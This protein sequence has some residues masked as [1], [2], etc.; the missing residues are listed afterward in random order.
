MSV[1][2]DF[3]GSSGS[4][5]V[6]NPEKR[7]ADLLRVEQAKLNRLVISGASDTQID[8]L[9]SE[10]DALRMSHKQAMTKAQ[11][12]YERVL[13]AREQGW[14]KE[15]T[16][17]KA[18][19]SQIQTEL[20]HLKGEKD[21]KERK[22]SEEQ[23]RLQQE[24][25]AMKK[26]SKLRAEEQH[27]L[28]EYLKNQKHNSDVVAMIRLQEMKN[29]L[30]M[31]RKL[32]ES[33]IALQETTKNLQ[34][35]LYQLE[36]S[37]P[38]QALLKQ[39]RERN[40]PREKEIIKS[41]IDIIRSNIKAAMSAETQDAKFVFFQMAKLGGIIVL[42]LI[43]I[44]IMFGSDTENAPTTQGN[45]QSADFSQILNS[46]SLQ[47]LQN[48]S[49]V[50]SRNFSTVWESCNTVVDFLQTNISK[51]AIEKLNSTITESTAIPPNVT[52]GED[53]IAPNVTIGEVAIAPNSIPAQ[54]MSAGSGILVTLVALAYQTQMY[55]SGEVNELNTEVRN[56]QQNTDNLD[57][58]YW[59]R[60]SQ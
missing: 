16:N 38:R 28:I 41:N 57:G 42:M 15:Q 35:K 34:E 55:P 45:Q 59:S 40:A 51:N 39:V 9:R 24:L 18:Q 25:D 21:S 46:S 52:I 31:V 4:F 37:E 17:L 30:L 49:S 1:E 20:A 2:Y 60:V 32:H 36:P 44:F 23:N 22:W 56:L 5:R 6:T 26:E 43:A 7:L 29:L 11:D 53:A 47:G 13:E 27:K 3:D 54:I 50:V 33:R 58:P 12:E 19:N 8:E 10:M 48:A 14:F